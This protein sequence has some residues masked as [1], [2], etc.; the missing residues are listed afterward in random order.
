[1][2]RRTTSHATVELF[3]FLAVLVCVMGAL[4]F[5]LLVMTRQLRAAAVAKAQAELHQTASADDLPQLPRFIDDVPVDDDPADDAPAPFPVT[6]TPLTPE[7][8]PEPEPEPQP[9]IEPERLLPA[10]DYAAIAKEQAELD[11]HWQTRVAELERRI[12]ESKTAQLRRQLLARSLAQQAADLEAELLQRE[13]ELARMMG[14]LSAAEDQATTEDEE[15]ARLERQIALLRQQLKQ[16]ANQQR[17]A[18]AR[19]AVVPFDGKSG[20]TRRPILI[21]CRASGIRFL[22]E[23]VTLTPADLDGFSPQFNPLAAGTMA[24]VDYWSRNPDA[25]GEEPYPMLI[26]RPDGTLAY[27]LAMKLL[28][29]TKRSFG[30]ELV[31]DEVALQLPPLDTEAKRKLEAAIEAAFSRR[32]QAMQ[33]LAGPYGGARAGA[34]QPPSTLPQRGGAGL[35]PTLG[36][37][38]N[39]SPISPPRQ[40]VPGSG[41]AGTGQTNAGTPRTGSSR[42]P[43]G[44]GPAIGRQEAA[45]KPSAR[46]EFSL[47]DLEDGPKVGDRSWEDLDRFE[48]QQFRRQRQQQQQ[49][50][51]QSQQSPQRSG[52]IADAPD[53]PVEPRVLSPDATLSSRPTMHEPP[54]SF[55]EHSGEP[56]PLRPLTDNPATSAPASSMPVVTGPNGAPQPPNSGFGTAAVSPGAR[57]RPATIH[58]EGTPGSLQSSANSSNE[59]APGGS[60][61]WQ[62]ST[63][64][65]R[66]GPGGDSAPSSMSLDDAEREQF[67]SFQRDLSRKTG[68]PAAMPYEQLQRRRW[69]PHEPG[70]SIG[71]ERRVEIRVDGEQFIVNGEDVIPLREAN[72]RQ[73]VFHQ[74][75]STIDQQAQTWGQPGAGLFWVP[76]LRFVVSPGG[77]AQYERIA[78]L[79][80]RSGLSHR[81]EQTLDRATPVSREI[82]P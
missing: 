63:D 53:A 70:A 11:A 8:L 6:M 38:G 32:E 20:T 50:Q 28:S 34:Y 40:P 5:L 31:T 75:L 61:D 82:A 72:N 23:D 51:Q 73:E 74:L 4:I 13:A 71:V 81:V 7:P 52:Q 68:R 18:S 27:Y 62:A 36:G 77:N 2:P 44:V 57:P 21:E 39:A 66:P 80:T 17:D 56:Q 15:R 59:S 45:T 42:Q 41:M 9:P 43:G 12:E 1:M 58:P 33:Q 79:V 10:V 47:S 67:P 26:V 22:P 54:S 64:A 3:P 16:L 14:R 35:N 25:A 78:P 65:S 76:N 37:G 30:Y 19:F 60:A 24:L 55:P 69:G 29:G 49:R 48:G 46:Q